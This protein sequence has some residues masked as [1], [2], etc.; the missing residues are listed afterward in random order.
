M[1]GMDKSKDGAAKFGT[2]GSGI[3]WTGCR[4]NGADCT[5]KLNMLITLGWCGVFSRLTKQI[6]ETSLAFRAS[7]VA[8]SVASVNGKDFLG[9]ASLPPGQGAI[10]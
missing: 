9:K 2:L 4:G 6:V 8:W 1:D 10:V 7:L 3:I 5:Q